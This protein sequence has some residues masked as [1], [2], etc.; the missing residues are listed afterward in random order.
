MYLSKSLQPESPLFEAYL[1]HL[2][3]SI[4]SKGDI[5]QSDNTLHADVELAA[6]EIVELLPPLAVLVSK[7]N[8]ESCIFS[9]PNIRRLYREAWFNIVVHGISPRSSL[10]QQQAN[11]L[12]TLAVCSPPLVAD[13]RA[14]NE[15]ESE[16]ELN[17]ILRRGMSPPRA[18]EQKR[19]L[20]AFLPTCETEIRSLSYAKV[21]FLSAAHMVEILRAEAGDCTSLLPYFID[22]SVNGSAMANCMVAIATEVTNVYLKSTLSAHYEVNASPGV[23]SQLALIL[24]GC[25]HRILRVQQVAASCADKIIMQMP[26]SLCQKSSLF[27]LLELLTMMWSSCLDGE[28]DEYNWRSTYTSVRGNI[29]VA[30]SDDYGFRK[31]TLNAFHKRARIWV[32]TVINI[33]PLDVKGLLQVGFSLLKAITPAN[34]K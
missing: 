28:L 33:A 20:M 31:K 2:L 22:P 27:A 24:A 29:S 10:G 9:D 14:D 30:L 8:K 26:S 11:D 23:A 13:D 1:A 17:T 32:M 16:I 12:R 3:E 21:I 18:A 25:C 19:H 34:L 15:S 4:I 6:R 5:H 7:V